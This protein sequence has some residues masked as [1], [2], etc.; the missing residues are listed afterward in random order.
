MKVKEERVMK[1]YRDM[2]E[3]WLKDTLKPVPDMPKK[4]RTWLADKAWIFAAIIAGLAVVNVMFTFFNILS[5]VSFLGNAS[6]YSNIYIT[7]PYAGG[8]L[9]SAIIS[10]LYSGVLA[11]LYYRAL[12]PLREKRASGWR[13]L[14]LILLL[15]GIVSII[16]AVLTFNI[17]YFIGGI[18]GGAISFLIGGYILLQLKREFVK[19]K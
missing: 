7:S 10:L 5:Y 15:S 16:D 17:F 3:S 4:V 14:F 2:V 9:P 13:T 18:I 6:S 11:Y 19:G 12:D 8:W 1:K